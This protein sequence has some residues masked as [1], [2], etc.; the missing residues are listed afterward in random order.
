MM[1]N[2]PHMYQLFA[3][4]SMS[5]SEMTIAMARPMS[6]AAMSAM[7]SRGSSAPSFMV[8]Q[9]AL[10]TISTPAE[11]ASRQRKRRSLSVPFQK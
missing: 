4:M 9:V 11:D 10:V 3:K 6:T 1:P 2:E 5:M 7:E 8:C